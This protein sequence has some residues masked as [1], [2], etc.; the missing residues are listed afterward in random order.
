MKRAAI[1]L[2][3]AL[4]GCSS[5]PVM[6]NIVGSWQGAQASELVARWG[7]PTTVVNRG[8]H[9]LLVWES[10]GTAVVPSSSFTSGQV[11]R[12]GSFT[13]T[14]VSRPGFVYETACIRSMK[15]RDGVVV[16]G[17]WAGNNCP[18]LTWSS[19]YNRWQR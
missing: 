10:Y 8:D 3:L 12:D 16:D 2:C 6:N 14:T 1:A 9:E 4:T 15:I 5:V 7:Y 11:S 19:P 18:V 17:R 13:A